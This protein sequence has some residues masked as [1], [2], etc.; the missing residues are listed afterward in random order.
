LNIIVHHSLTFLTGKVE[1]HREDRGKRQTPH[2][3]AMSKVARRNQARQLRIH[4]HEKKENES[5]IFHGKKHVAILPLSDKLDTQALIRELNESVHALSNMAEDGFAKV[6]VER[7]KRN[8]LYMPA[9]RNLIN[10]LDTCRLADWVVLAA[11]PDQDFS[12]A[13][14]ALLRAIEGQGITNV[15]A[16]VQETSQGQPT[17]SSSKVAVDLSR[18]INRYFPTLDKVY[19]TANKSDCANLVR[20]LCTAT[21]KGIR[22]R[23]ERSWMLIEGIDWETPASS[24]AEQTTIALTGVV[25]GRCLNP[26]RV[27]HV[28][29]W[30]DFQIGRIVES[31]THNRK[32]K[33]DEMNVEEAPNEYVP[34]PGRDD[35]ETLAP[36]EADMADVT[37]TV[38]TSEHKGVLLDDHHYFSDDDSHLPA[39][40]KKLPR[41]T[42]TYQSAWYLDDVSDSDSDILDEEDQ[43]GDVVMESAVSLGPADGVVAADSGD[44][45][46]EAGPSEYPESEMHIEP[47]PDDEERDLEDFRASR[48]KAAEEDLEFPDEIE[49]NPNVLARERLA[50]YRGL[51]SLRTSEWNKEED[52]PY[53]PN[54]YRRL[55][56]IADYKKSRKTATNEALAGGATPGMRVQ[57]QLLD[58]PSSLKVSPKPLCLFSLLRH[59]HKHTVV[60][61][62]MTL[63]SAFPE[64]VKAKEKLIV[65]IGPR[66]LIINP[67]FSTGGNTPNDVHK[68]ERF[69]HPGRNAVASFIGPLT[70][71]SIPVLVFKRTAQS[72]GFAPALVDT[73]AAENHSSESGTLQLI[74]TATTIPPSNSRVIA[75]RVILTGHPYKIH[76][77]LVTVRYMFFNKED[78]A[79]F[80]ALPLW[81]KRGRQGFIKESLGTH[82]YFKATFDGKINPMDAIGV[83]LYKRVWPRPARAWTG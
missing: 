80:S 55:L 38:A 3:Q 6:E 26:D 47:T 48:K 34:S 54:E 10:A 5:V 14:D 15:V 76:K 71:G 62:N 17:S 20:S 51:K 50:K 42:S 16:V 25:R 70:W 31:P 64:P 66:R 65:Q 82:G 32:R 57:V 45:M 21:T 33:A 68:F 11:T 79:W 12:G 2:Q 39:P 7:F 78:I 67:V 30:G 49:L 75:K 43:D 27:V 72:D 19:T 69:L 9:E 61:L 29:G 77:K 23:D 56:Q 60:N 40:P 28:P 22:W 74:G 83:S 8:L 36:E 35:L 52:V 53:Q 13:E 59:E 73:M 24:S 1:R 81:T 63:D 18:K 44:A 41:G 37:S 4:H 46:T 58:V